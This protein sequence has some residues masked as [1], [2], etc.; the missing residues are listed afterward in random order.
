M[1]GH[2]SAALLLALCAACMQPAEARA[3]LAP[4]PARVAKESDGLK[5]AIFAGGCF[6][7]VE[8]VFSHVKGVT[9]A[10]SGFHGG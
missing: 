3:V 5:R 2:F 6:W 4:A 10:V 1:K 9:S 8:G 7:G